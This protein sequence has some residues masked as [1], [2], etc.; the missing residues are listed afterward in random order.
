[1]K[2]N[3]SIYVKV[4]GIRFEL[5]DSVISV[6][7]ELVVPKKSSQKAKPKEN[8]KKILYLKNKSLKKIY[9]LFLL[10]GYNKIKKIKKKKE[11]LDSYH[12]IEILSILKENDIK[13]SENKNGV[14]FKYEFIKKTNNSNP[15]IH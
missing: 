9:F 3:E 11:T 6:L 14:Y 5:N 13:Y 8:K 12:H 1:M 15:K 4:I 10:N 7:G 2:I